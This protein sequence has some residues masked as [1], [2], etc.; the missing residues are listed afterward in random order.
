MESLA[1]RLDV[2]NKPIVI[3][4]TLVNGTAFSTAAW[5]GRVVLVEFWSTHCGPCVAQLPAIAKLYA[6]NK[7]Q[8]LE[9]LSIS[10]DPDADTLKLFLTRHPE[11]TWPQLLDGEL[12]KAPIA[13]SLGVNHWPNYFLIDRKGILH[14]VENPLESEETT[15]QIAR[16]LAE[17]E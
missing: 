9:V 1:K 11:L 14:Q 15:A 13:K 4:G 10:G 12:D 16:L 17:T 3:E 7:G 2:V 8:G 5:K 6:N